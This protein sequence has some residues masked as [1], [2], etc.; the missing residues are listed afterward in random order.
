VSLADHDIT[1]IK[2][3]G[4]VMPPFLNLH[5]IAAA[6]GDGLRPEFQALFERLAMASRSQLGVRSDG[7]LQAGPDPA[8]PADTPQASEPATVLALAA[9]AGRH[10][11]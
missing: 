4:P 3:E 1:S 5:A 9:A 7:M 8:T 10:E 6:R 2:R 11:D